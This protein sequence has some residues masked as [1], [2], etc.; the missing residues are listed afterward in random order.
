MSGIGSYPYSLMGYSYS[1]Y[2][3]LQAG[4]LNQTQ[5]QQTLQPNIQ[6]VPAFGTNIYSGQPVGSLQP[7]SLVQQQFMGLGQQQ[8]ALLPGT[9]RVESVPFPW[10]AHC[11]GGS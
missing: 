10:G 5:Q 1:P 7:N 2:L 8:P 4:I 3:Q 6:S 11:R 9:Q